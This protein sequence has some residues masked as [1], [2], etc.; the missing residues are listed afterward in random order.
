MNFPPLI[1][2]EANVGAASQANPTRYGIQN[3]L[4]SILRLAAGYI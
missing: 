3:P 2:L 4:A 1:W